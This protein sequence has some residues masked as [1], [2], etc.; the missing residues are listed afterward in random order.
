M[1]LVHLLQNPVVMHHAVAWVAITFLYL[2]LGRTALT[3]FPPA[4]LPVHPAM[5]VNNR[6]SIAQ[7]SVE[8][9]IGVVSLGLPPVL[10]LPFYLKSPYLYMLDN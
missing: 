9:A 7:S 10:P 6:G 3:A 2:F 1:E 4:W 5:R 8:G